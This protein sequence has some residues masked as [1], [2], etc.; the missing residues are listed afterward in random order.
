MDMLSPEQ[1]EKLESLRGKPFDTS[2]LQLG[3]RRRN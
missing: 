1:K 3:G 2:A